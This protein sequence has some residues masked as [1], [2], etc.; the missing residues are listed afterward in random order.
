MRRSITLI[1][2]AKVQRRVDANSLTV[3]GKV[4]PLE[5]PFVLLVDP[6]NLC[7]LRCKF[8][9][10]GNH[11]LIRKTG[12]YRGNLDFKLF[13]KIIGD[14]R[15]FPDPVK[16][17]R[18][19]K[20]GEPLINPR[21]SD[22]VKFAKDS[23]RVLRVDTTTNGLLLSPKLN[24]QIVAAGL[25]QINISV[26]GVNAGQI[27]EFTDTKVDF[28]RYCAN[29]RDLYENKGNCEIYIKAIRENLSPAQQEE[30]YSI[31]GEMS[32][33]IFLENLSPAWPEFEFAGMKMKFDCGHYGQPIVQRQ[34]CPYIFYIMVI[35]SDGKTSLCVGDW[36]HKLGYGDVSRQ[37]VKEVWLGDVIRSHRIAHLENRRTENSF[38]AACQVI[39]H[40]TL[41]NVDA[42]AK[43]IRQRLK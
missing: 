32:D 23:K 8:C 30:F 42:F 2:K 35:N 16:V 37:S 25:D 22:M 17:L 26:N 7:N 20:E 28:K 1:M 3:L 9:P 13:K 12:R 36:R 29:I 43:E 11:A 18:L 24:R 31:F 40:G 15:E 41:E 10:T 39:S 21:F 4:L 19:Y 5:T 33:R 6:S 14:L 27:H 38:C 34:V